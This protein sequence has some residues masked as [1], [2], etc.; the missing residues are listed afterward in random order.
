MGHNF[1]YDYVEYGYYAYYVPRNSFYIDVGNS[2]NPGVIDHHH[3]KGTSIFTSATRMVWTLLYNGSS[4]LWPNAGKTKQIIDNIAQND[5]NDVYIFTHRNPDL[6]SFLSMYILTYYLNYNEL[7]KISND[8]LD[9]VDNVDQGVF[10]D[11]KFE[12]HNLYFALEVMQIE[13]MSLSDKHELSDLR[14]KFFQ[15]IDQLIYSKKEPCDFIAES[16]IASGID[17]ILSQVHDPKESSQRVRVP[18]FRYAEGECSVQSR[19]A[20]LIDI[21]KDSILNIMKAKYRRAGDSVWIV[22]YSES[23]NYGKHRLVFSV[24]G[25]EELALFGFGWRLEKLEQFYRCS[26]YIGN[27]PE[28]PERFG[29]PRPG[30]DGPDPWYDGRNHNY[31]IVDSPNC[32]TILGE[33]DL[34]ELFGLLR[35]DNPAWKRHLVEAV[36][37][38]HRLIR[39]RLSESAGQAVDRIPTDLGLSLD[40]DRM[41]D[42]TRAVY[43]FVIDDH[44]A[45]SRVKEGLAGMALFNLD[46]TSVLQGKDQPFLESVQ[47][48]RRFSDC[49]AEVSRFLLAKGSLH[50][51]QEAVRLAE[52]AERLEHEQK[53]LFLDSLDAV[54]VP[55]R[56][57]IFLSVFELIRFVSPHHASPPADPPFFRIAEYT[58][59]FA[60]LKKWPVDEEC[61]VWNSLRQLYQ[62][63]DK[64]IIKHVGV[65]NPLLETLRWAKKRIELPLTLN[66]V[67][68]RLID[69]SNYN[70]SLFYEKNHLLV[71]DVLLHWYELTL[72]LSGSKERYCNMCRHCTEERFDKPY[73]AL[74]PA[75]N[76]IKVC[77]KLSGISDEET[78]IFELLKLIA[79]ETGKLFEIQ[80]KDPNLIIQKAQ[81]IS[82]NITELKDSLSRRGNSL[83][84]RFWYNTFIYECVHD[85]QAYFDRIVSTLT[86]FNHVLSSNDTD[87]IEALGCCLLRSLTMEQVYDHSGKLLPIALELLVGHDD[88][89]K[90]RD[91]RQELQLLKKVRAR[92]IERKKDA[93]GVTQS[94]SRQAELLRRLYL[95]EHEDFMDLSPALKKNM[96]GRVIAFLQ[97]SMSLDQ[98]AEFLD[99]FQ[100][101]KERKIPGIDPLFRLPLSSRVSIKS[102]FSGWIP[103]IAGFFAAVTYADQGGFFWYTLFLC[104]W[105]LGVLMQIVGSG[106]FLSS[107][108][109]KINAA[110]WQVG[111]LQK[112]K[113]FQAGP[114]ESRPVGAF[115]S[116][117]LLLRYVVPMILALSPFVLSDELK[118]FIYNHVQT[119][120]RFF[121]VILVFSAFSVFALFKLQTNIVQNGAK[122][123]I[124]LFSILWAQSFAFSYFLP[125]FLQN[126]PAIIANDQQKIENMLND[127]IVG[128]P[129][130]VELLKLGD[131]TMYAF[132]AATILF[133]FM[134]LF[135]AIFLEGLVKSR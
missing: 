108:T 98:A 119:P 121:S 130:L 50:A 86:H 132:P 55:E 52:I 70:D 40:L 107:Y 47:E 61:I 116:G 18:L 36:V 7:P 114:G 17:A 67:K 11:P 5:F 122:N 30:Y 101:R 124:C 73:L 32:G 64:D 72:F 93:H 88:F 133:S 38:A 43:D 71:L 31:T 115:V 91:V 106:R 25:S 75:Q 89:A 85:Q 57:Q 123:L 126:M 131:M 68:K 15:F 1:F 63:P 127:S 99:A 53:Q 62:L 94:N 129:R 82:T 10:D 79:V 117:Q 111:A 6:D 120:E 125:V 112:E 19:E 49:R 54:A 97:A 83:Q 81:N 60:Q 76:L 105:L 104:V 21:H 102:L 96:F 109:E 92:F 35:F 128:I 29:P 90:P 20:V 113:P 100:G 80:D 44:A 28:Y 69:A 56:M 134:C 39:S 3:T 135:V 42:I 95:S 13:C 4:D 74:P 48:L 26:D 59:L 110:G 23:L 78:E 16:S 24:D 65:N 77:D 58:E 118:T 103:M 87:Q 84:S 22:R 9:L 27:F 45:R 14:E 51:V 33:L 8:I 66:E 12:Q 34:S 37:E 46:W 41:Y 2:F